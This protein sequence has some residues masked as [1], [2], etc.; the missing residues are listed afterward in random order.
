MI[1][2]R[3]LGDCVRLLVS[4]GS[5]EWVA[6]FFECSLKRTWERLKTQLQR[7]IDAYTAHSTGAVRLQLIS[8]R[9]TK[10]TVKSP[11]LRMLWSYAEI[12][13][14]YFVVCS[15]TFELGH[16]VKVYSELDVDGRCRLVIKADGN[17]NEYLEFWQVSRMMLEPLFPRD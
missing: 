10:L 3:E 2:D 13:K 4:D 11:D 6:A 1:D 15:S 9:D 7:D 16:E 14:G 12:Q 17:E 8:D 5:P